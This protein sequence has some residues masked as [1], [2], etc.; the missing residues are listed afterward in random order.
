M[1][2]WL[3]GL[4]LG[5]IA[6]TLCVILL[7][8]FG[9]RSIVFSQTGSGLWFLVDCTSLVGPA[10]GTSWCFRTTPSYDIEVWDGATWQVLATTGH[11]SAG[12]IYAIQVSDGAGAFLDSHARMV[13]Y[14]ASRSWFITPGNDVTGITVAEPDGAVI[15]YGNILSDSGFYSFTYIIGNGNTI[16]DPDD[17]V[18]LGNN[19]NLG[20]CTDGFR[21][22]GSGNTGLACGGMAFGDNNIL[23]SSSQV[24][25]TGN[26]GG[27]LI[28]GNGNTS[29]SGTN[30]WML[31]V[32][33]TEMDSIGGGQMVSSFFLGAN[34]TID[35]AGTT[36]VHAGVISLQSN[37]LT[38][39]TDT[40]IIDTPLLSLTGAFTGVLNIAARTVFTGNAATCGINCASVSGNDR[41]GTITMSSGSFTTVGVNFSTTLASAPLCTGSTNQATL[42]GVAVTAVS[43]TRAT[44]GIIANSGGIQVN[45]QCFE[46]A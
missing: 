33:L 41:T 39:V 26:T 5:Y 20:T 18:V 42:G 25:G 2:R 1:R 16:G 35:L 13:D 28:L 45:Y 46:K 29:L 24:F 19:N 17:T 37:T 21:V 15:G 40:I 3:S 34:A 12:P 4:Q 43:A 31:G 14:G 38:P 44:F 27:E 11:N 23:S 22:V 9:P 8:Y 32:A 7:G 10:Q 36:P 6:V 30:A